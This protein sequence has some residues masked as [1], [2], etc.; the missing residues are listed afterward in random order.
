MDNLVLSEQFL[1]HSKIYFDAALIIEQQFIEHDNPNVFYPFL[2]LLRHSFELTLKSLILSSVHNQDIDVEKMLVITSISKKNSFKLS[3]T[4]SLLNLFDQIRVIY[5]NQVEDNQ[6]LLSIFDGEEMDLIRTHLVKF[7]LIDLQGDY[8]K[9]P[10]TTK[11]IDTPSKVWSEKYND[12]AG[13]ITPDNQGWILFYDKDGEEEVVFVNGLD[14]SAMAIRE[15]LLK[16]L[17]TL[18]KISPFNTFQN[19]DVR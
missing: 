12:I 1:N 16:D 3:K 5:K 15:I 18:A 14:E 2:Y 10:F 9:Y 7:N 11:G 13:E 4:H 8:F 6:I 17:L 19:I